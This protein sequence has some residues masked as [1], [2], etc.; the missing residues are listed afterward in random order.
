MVKHNPIRHQ[1]ATLTPQSS[2]C[3][4]VNHLCFLF[5]VLGNNNLITYCG[6]VEKFEIQPDLLYSR[7]MNKKLLLALLSGALEFLLNAGNLI[8]N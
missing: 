2:C 1:N 7:Q 5:S 3:M 8:I 4:D 6:S